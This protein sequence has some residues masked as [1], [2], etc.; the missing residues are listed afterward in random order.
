MVLGLL[1]GFLVSSGSS[2]QSGLTVITNFPMAGE[3]GGVPTT[4]VPWATDAASC[5]PS[6]IT[7]PN[8]IAYDVCQ[9]PLTSVGDAVMVQQIAPVTWSAG[10]GTVDM[11]AKLWQNDG[12]P[13]VGTWTFAI[14]AGCA[15]DG[16]SFVYGTNTGV[17]GTPPP[18]FAY[19]S[20]GRIHINLNGCFPGAAIQGWIQ[21]RAD[22]GGS[23]N[24]TPRVVSI[25]MVIRGS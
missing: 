13:G 22:Q 20:F 17:G 25:Q 23:S 8:T 5:I 19:Q 6:T 9:V 2:V 16:E 18:Q 7:G 11:Y 10:S 3:S 21:R 1:A 4:L 12:V 15:G 24:V 14:Y